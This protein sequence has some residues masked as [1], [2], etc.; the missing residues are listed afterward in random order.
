MTKR[1]M[2]GRTFF[3]NP[4]QREKS[5][6]QWKAGIDLHVPYSFWEE[7]CTNDVNPLGRERVKRLACQVT[8]IT[9]KFPLVLFKLFANYHLSPRAGYS[10]VTA[11]TKVSSA[12]HDHCR[13][14]LSYA[15]SRS[16][17]SLACLVYF[18]TVCLTNSVLRCITMCG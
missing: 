1:G 16:E 3:W 15:R 10:V 8:K 18:Q 5:H 11:V 2:N 14:F 17:C 7:V 9:E 6:T 12:D 4:R 13:D